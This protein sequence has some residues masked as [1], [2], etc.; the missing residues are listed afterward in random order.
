MENKILEK[1]V[2]AKKDVHHLVPPATPPADPEVREAIG[3]GF[4]EYRRRIAAIRA[5]HGKSQRRS[6]LN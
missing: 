1:T 4:D 5:A 3:E 2:G 6:I